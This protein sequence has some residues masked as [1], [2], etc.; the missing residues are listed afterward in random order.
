MSIPLHSKLRRM[1]RSSINYFLIKLSKKKLNIENIPSDKI[2]RILIVRINYRI[3]N[4]IFLTP[5]INALAKKM[6]H[7]KIDILI[8]AKFIAPILEPMNNVNVVYD[9]PRSLLKNPFKLINKVKEINSNNYDLLIS[10]VISSGSANISTMLINAQFKLGFYCEKTWG[11]AN[12][13]I[14][15]PDKTAHEALIPLAL[16]KAF[17][18]EHEYLSHL[19]DINLS[20]NERA[21]G[22][23]YLESLLEK[24]NINKHAENTVIGVFRD[25][26]HDKKIED[27]WWQPFLEQ[28]LIKNPHYILVDI[29][30]PNINEVIHSK[31]LPVSFDNLRELGCFMSSLD[32]FICADTGPMHLAS[33]SYTPVIALF[34]AT[35]EDKY[36]PLGE[37]DR[38]VNVL[39][40]PL[41]LV[42]NEVHNNIQEFN[43]KKSE[44]YKM[45]I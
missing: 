7:A 31:G 18:S 27:G 13:T 2:N 28:L 17:K 3:G 44:N 33:A 10:P 12:I 36:G 32:F 40:K 16:M 1:L 42:I 9:T 41:E 24:H 43:N 8:G 22:E 30:P 34:N 15:Y 20:K 26:R 38:V 11:A 35:S 29:L 14:P 19:L 4:I 6:P 21:R 25:A 37:Y 39:H 45:L 23:N 5:L